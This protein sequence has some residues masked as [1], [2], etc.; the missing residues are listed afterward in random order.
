MSLGL[1]GRQSKNVARNTQMNLKRI[2]MVC[3]VIVCLLCSVIQSW[4]MKQKYLQDVCVHTYGRYTATLLCYTEC[5][6]NI[7][8]DLLHFNCQYFTSEYPSDRSSPLNL[9]KTIP[10]VSQSHND[11]SS[12]V[13]TM[14]QQTAVSRI[15]QACGL[16][17]I[18]IMWR[19]LLVEKSD[20]NL[21]R[22]LLVLYEV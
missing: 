3:C 8:K 20:F 11:G 16:N 12:L 21:Y 19:W 9:A 4:C 17:M 10:V 15:Y 7:S 1:N 22:N 14:T 18:A 13:D 6:T 2:V 5:Y